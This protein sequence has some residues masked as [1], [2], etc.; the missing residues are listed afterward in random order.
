MIFGARTAMRTTHCQFLSEDLKLVVKRIVQDVGDSH[1]YEGELFVTRVL[2]S[3]RSSPTTP[4][5]NPHL[6]VEEEKRGTLLG[7][8]P[9]RRK[10]ILLLVKEGFC[11]MEDKGSKDMFLV[12][13]CKNYET[14]ARRHLEEYGRKNHV[15]QIVY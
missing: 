5:G 7:L 13:R 6:I 12:L 9:Y 1:E 15:T 11:D 3:R 2:P 8:I 10:R 14:V 4:A